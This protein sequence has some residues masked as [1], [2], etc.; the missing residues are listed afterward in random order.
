MAMNRARNTPGIGTA[1]VATPRRVLFTDQGAM[2]LPNAG[3]LDGSES[4]D[5]TNTGDLVSLQPGLVL[6]KITTGGLW[7]PTIVGLTT[8]AYTTGGVTL[9]VAA[10]TAV[11]MDRIAGSSG[12]SEFVCI[13]APTATGTVASTAFDHSAI[14]T[15]TGAVTVTSLGVNK[16]AGSF[17]CRNDGR[18]PPLGLLTT[19]YPVR[20][21]DEDGDA[22]DQTLPRLAVGGF[23]A[24]G[25]IINYPAA[26]NT[27]LTAW[28]KA[29]LR[30]TGPWA[31]TDDFG[32][33]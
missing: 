28:L 14:N 8:A 13:G 2:I 27:S 1:R 17:I 33:S 11:E 9:T 30:L 12:S 18:G 5:P 15:S 26:A 29:Q 25:Q 10:A 21:T 20:V 4:R 23:A 6:G 24:T 22:L 32:V 7:A 31:F 16:H 3:V 19:D